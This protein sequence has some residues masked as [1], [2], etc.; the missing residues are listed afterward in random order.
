VQHNVQVQESGPDQATYRQVLAN[1]EFRAMFLA[2]GL[3]VV[4]DQ[5]AR[6]AVALLVFDRSGSALAAAAVYACSFLT[7]LLG[8]PLLSTLADRQRRRRLMVTCDV[9]RMLLIALLAVPGV[10]LWA[11]FVVLVAVGLFAP[12]F[13][14]ARSALVADILSGEAYV[15]GTTLNQSLSQTGQIVGFVAGGALVAVMGVQGALLV[16][17]ATFALSAGLLVRAVHDRPAPGSEAPGVRALVRQ[18]AEGARLVAGTPRLRTLLGW[19]LL[20][21]ALVIGPEGL[22]VTISDELGGGAVTTGVLTAA[23]PI[24]FVVGSL[25]L[26]RLPEVRRERLF[27]PMVL[28]SVAAL[29]L[30]PLATSAV[31]VTLLW[32]VAGVGNALQLIANA[33]FV[34]AVPA[35]QRGRA[36]GIA[37]TALMSIQGIVLLAAGALAELIGARETVAAL[38]LLGVG[39]LVLSGAI[40]HRTLPRRTSQKANLA[41]PGQGGRM[42]V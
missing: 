20:S 21:A 34:L 38:A 25:L 39:V 11:V 17:A 9:A 29:A 40:T 18:T 2:G 42:R 41:K 33:A 7:W 27:L 35:Q 30:T 5:L 28:L 37:V 36:F 8:G 19:A 1:R 10:P 14:A 24:G 31:A 13:E 3:S 23:V 26:A 16:D 15:R 4:G 32:V 12:P 6:I 22:A